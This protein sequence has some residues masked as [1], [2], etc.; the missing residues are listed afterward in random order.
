MKRYL[1]SLL[2][3]V[4]ML[5]IVTCGNEPPEEYYQ[6]TPEDSAAIQAVLDANPGYLLTTDGFVE[7][8]VPIALNPVGITGSDSFF[9]GD[10]T[11]IKQHVD[12]TALLFT[13]MNRYQDLWFAKDTT[14]TVALYDTFLAVSEMHA[15]IRYTL[16]YF[17]QG[18]TTTRVDTVVVN[19]TSVY[20]TLNIIGDGNRRIFLEPIREAKIDEETGDTVMA[21]KEPREWVMKRV[22]YG[23]YHYPNAGAT[24]PGLTRVTLDPGGDLPIDT[25]ISASTDTLYLGHAMDRFR[26]VDSLLVYTAGDTLDIVA[27]A[28]AGFN[29]D[30]VTFYAS[31]GGTNRVELPNGSGSLVLKNETGITNLYFEVV[32]PNTYYYALP[33]FEYAATVWLVPVVLQ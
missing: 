26:A 16:Y 9:K 30:S 14:C 15:N 27:T 33:P 11:V 2:V 3:I 5:F 25:I 12:S 8:Y 7:D 29:A 6:G 17:W 1:L 18:D 31:C 23:I 22:A 20:N 4:T 21:I 10:S 32:E 24:A 19:D 28:T 13:S